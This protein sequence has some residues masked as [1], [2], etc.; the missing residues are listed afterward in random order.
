MN[1]SPPHWDRARD[2][3]DGVR[4]EAIGLLRGAAAHEPA[5]DLRAEILSGLG[6]ALATRYEGWGAAADLDDAIA[7]LSAADIAE[8]PR[9]VHANTLSML[10]GA[11]LSRFEEHGTPADLAASVEAGQRAQR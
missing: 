8:A 10:C 7:A 3:L 2:A 4:N 9:Q 6:A 5:P 1:A 11:L